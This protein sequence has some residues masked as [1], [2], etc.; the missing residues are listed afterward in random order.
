MKLHNLLSNS[1]YSIFIGMLFRLFYTAKQ[2][3]NFMRYAAETLASWQ[4]HEKTGIGRSGPNSLE[5]TGKC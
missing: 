5:V 4:P 1:T 3:Y 2:F